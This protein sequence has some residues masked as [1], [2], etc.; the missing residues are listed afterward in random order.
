MRALILWADDRSTN[1]GVRALGAGT[2]ALLRSVDPEVEVEFQSFGRG[3]APLPVQG[4]RSLVRERLTGRAGLQ[5]WL[6]SF[7]VVVDTRAGDSFADVYGPTRLTTMSTLAELAT[8]AGTPVVLGPQTIGPFTTPRGRAT[9]RWS[10]RRARLVLARDTVSAAYAARLGRPVDATATDVVFA[11]PVPEV[12]RTRDVLLNVS[13]LLWQPGPHVDASAYR[14]TVTDVYRR[15]VADGRRVAL[16]THVLPS[17]VPDNDLPAVEEVARTVAP[18]AEVLVPADL[19]EVRRMVA[20]ANLVLGSRMHACLNA[21]SVGTPAVPL[22]YSR[23]FAP[24]LA[25]LGWAHTVDLRTAARPA[26]DAVRLASRS[27]L[28]VEAKA[29]RERAQELLAPAV[30]ALEG[31]R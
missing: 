31:L 10:L 3:P 30:H 23:K 11:L 25:D 14:A 2:A 16:L 20:S 5:R 6:G 1:L 17:P 24:L 13:G 21:L 27:G 4:V 22:A 29:V 7:D 28:D 9:A 15:L 19:E 8:Q 18:D 12:P 26:D